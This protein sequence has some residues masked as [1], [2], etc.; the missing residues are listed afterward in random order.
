[1]FTPL[2]I[3]QELIDP[4]KRINEDFQSFTFALSSG[5]VV[6]GL[7]LEETP[8]SVKV[9]ENPLAKSEPLVIPVGEI[10]Q[11]AKSTTSIMPQ[12]LLDK[13]THEEILDLIAYIAARGDQQHSLFSPSQD[14]Q[15]EHHHH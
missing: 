13:L 10:E 6:T 9:I 7:V 14:Q 2:D 4:S 1:M 3:L 11:R 12:G 15:H 5:Q 8:D